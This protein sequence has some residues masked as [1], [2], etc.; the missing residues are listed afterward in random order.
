M[1]A[2][3]SSETSFEFQRTTPCYI[4][5]DRILHFFFALIPTLIFKNML[6]YAMLCAIFLNVKFME[7]FCATDS[8]SKMIIDK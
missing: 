1:K 3:N 8:T 7:Y 6:Q 4:P 5:E 2:I